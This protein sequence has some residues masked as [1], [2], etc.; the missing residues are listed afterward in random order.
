MTGT[1]DDYELDAERM[2]H[3]EIQHD[4]GH[5]LVLDD[6]AINEHDKSLAAELRHVLQDAPDIVVFHQI[7]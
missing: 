4:V 1:K 5:V 6:A 2:E 7:K 3:G